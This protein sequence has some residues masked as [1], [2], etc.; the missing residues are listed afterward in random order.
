MNYKMQEALK[1]NKKNFII[2]AILWL[3]IAVVFVSPMA[4][5]SLISVTNEAFDFGLFIT[6][7]G[8]LIQAERQNS[9]PIKVTVSFSEGLEGTTIT[10]SFLDSIISF[11]KT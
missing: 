10:T 5:S 2:F 4:Y 8:E 11:V 7:F 6:N 1:R 3:I 9:N